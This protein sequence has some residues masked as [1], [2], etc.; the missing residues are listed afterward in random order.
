MTVPWRFSKAHT[1]SATVLVDALEASGFDGFA[2]A[3]KIGFVSRKT[4][5]PVLTASALAA[6]E[7]AHPG[8][9]PF[10]SINSM[11]GAIYENSRFMN[12]L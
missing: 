6:S 1:W 8:L 3:R 4:G 12:V 7:G 11:V 9:P 10:S 2:H 5:A